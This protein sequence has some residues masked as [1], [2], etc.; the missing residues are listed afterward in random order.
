[1]LW[2]VMRFT[3]STVSTNALVKETIS[4]QSPALSN[5]GTINHEARRDTTQCVQIEAC[6][7][8][9][10]WRPT[11]NLATK[12][13]EKVLEAYFTLRWNEGTTDMGFIK[14]SR[15]MF[16]LEWMIKAILSYPMNIRKKERK[17]D[18]L[19]LNIWFMYNCV[20]GLDRKLQEIMNVKLRNL[21]GLPTIQ[22]L[23]CFV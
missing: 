6:A 15:F 13:A 17:I 5:K 4:H 10:K 3:T 14:W 2:R 21:S 16:K 20:L 22:D 19:Q 1:M 18:N 9:W 23:W 7:F 11:T 12:C 8:V